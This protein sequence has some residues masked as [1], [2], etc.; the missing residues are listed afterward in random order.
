MGKLEILGIRADKREIIPRNIRHMVATREL[1]RTHKQFEQSDALREKL[2]QLGY[3]V[4]DTSDGSA[5]IH[6]TG[7]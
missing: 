3:T 2:N 5:L 7:I 1:F 6:K 4:Q